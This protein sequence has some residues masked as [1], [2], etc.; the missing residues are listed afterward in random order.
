MIWEYLVVGA[1]IILAGFF[2]WRNIY[3]RLTGK[4]KCCEACP[5]RKS[6]SLISPDPNSDLCAEAM[7]GLKRNAEGNG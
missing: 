1:A 5:H 7:E 6:C 4:E 2:I 3:L